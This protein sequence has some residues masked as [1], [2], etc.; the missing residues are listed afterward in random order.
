M[1]T[2]VTP[3]LWPPETFESIVSPRELQ[4]EHEQMFNQALGRLVPVSYV[5]YHTS[6]SGLS[7]WWSSHGPY[8]VNPVGSFILEQASRLDA[9][10]GYPFRR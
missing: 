3:Q 8:R 2:G 7:T 5:C 4:S 1:G 9:F 10:S 6:T